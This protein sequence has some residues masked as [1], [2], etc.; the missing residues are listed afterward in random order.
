MITKKGARI[1]ISPLYGLMARLC[2]ILNWYLVLSCVSVLEW[3]DVGRD[4]L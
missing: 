3:P 1:Q 4:P 2:V